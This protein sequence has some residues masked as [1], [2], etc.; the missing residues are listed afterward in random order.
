MA[1]TFL[2]E[3]VVSSLWSVLDYLGI[4][5]LGIYFHSQSQVGDSVVLGTTPFYVG[6]VRVV[7]TQP[8]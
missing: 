3:T 8:R 2:L 4:W 1:R 6:V 7:A 5:E